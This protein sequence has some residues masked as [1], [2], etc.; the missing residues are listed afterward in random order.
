[1]RVAK[2]AAATARS[3]P[4]IAL[5]IQIVQQL[6]G[7]GIKDLCSHRNMNRQIG[8]VVTGSIRT[9]AVQTTIGN[10]PRVVS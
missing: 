7:F 5:A 3:Q 6:A 10:V 9:F 4:A 8:A 1:V 2:S